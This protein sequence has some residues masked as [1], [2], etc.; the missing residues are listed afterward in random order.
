MDVTKTIAILHD[1]T[2]RIAEGIQNSSSIGGSIILGAGIKKREGTVFLLNSVGCFSHS[3]HIRLGVEIPN[4]SV[5]HGNCYSTRLPMILNLSSPKHN[6][7]RNY[8]HDSLR[9]WVITGIGRG[10]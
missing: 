3:S 5:K 10:E 1:V 4:V 8:G 7:S 9:I 2:L 6:R